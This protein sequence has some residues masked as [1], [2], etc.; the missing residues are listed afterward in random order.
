MGAARLGN[1]EQLC[2]LCPEHRVGEPGTWAGLRPKN[3]AHFLS[4]T[5]RLRPRVH[6]LAWQNPVRELKRE[7]I[8]K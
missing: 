3:L 4:L 6:T 8:Y 2:K 5:Q 7:I 1:E